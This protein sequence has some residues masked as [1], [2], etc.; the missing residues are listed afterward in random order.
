MDDSG[1][2]DPQQMVSV[3]PASPT[4]CLVHAGQLGSPKADEDL[5]FLG[6][7]QATVAAEAMPGA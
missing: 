1:K 6:F 5:R 2:P 3:G 4:L 7:P